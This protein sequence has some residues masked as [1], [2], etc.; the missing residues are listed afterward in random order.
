[1]A[2]GD[3]AIN[4]LLHRLRVDIA[5]DNRVDAVTKRYL[6]Q[7]LIGHGVP[8][9]Q[10]RIACMTI[11]VI[12]EH[13]VVHADPRPIA[14]R[15][16]QYHH[17]IIAK[18]LVQLVQLFDSDIAVGAQADHHPLTQVVRCGIRLGDL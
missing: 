5:A 11:D 7:M 13:L 16:D 6:V 14:M 8:I 3:P 2:G 4:C 15:V 9:H 12:G 1:M 18:L 10:H 17:P